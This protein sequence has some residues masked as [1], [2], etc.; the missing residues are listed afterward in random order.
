MAWNFFGKKET[1][2]EKKDTLWNADTCCKQNEKA[3]CACGCTQSARDSVKLTDAEIA[4][5]VLN[6]LN[7]I[8]GEYSAL[9]ASGCNC[10]EKLRSCEKTRNALC[11]YVKNKK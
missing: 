8:C 9:L 1:K 5:D 3:D 7:D 10:E 2:E 11:E 6:E 4:E